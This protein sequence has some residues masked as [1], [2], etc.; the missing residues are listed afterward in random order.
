MKGK[1]LRQHLAFMLLCVAVPMLIARA[2]IAVSCMPSQGMQRKKGELLFNRN[3]NSSM[4][5]VDCTLIQPPCTEGSTMLHI[6]NTAGRAF[7]GTCQSTKGIHNLMIATAIHQR[8]FIGSRCSMFGTSVLSCLLYYYS[9]QYCKLAS[10][11]FISIKEETKFGK[12]NSPNRT[13][14]SIEIVPYD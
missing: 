2:I 14:R 13:G 8:E 7:S 10:G 12:T 9:G 3:Y 1:A 11:G 4:T 5:P 6:Q